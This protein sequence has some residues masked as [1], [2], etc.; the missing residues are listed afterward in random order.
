MIDNPW[1]AYVPRYLARQ[2]LD[3]PDQN[4]IGR[5]NRL[6]VVAMFSDISGF[7]PISEA[8]AA[9]GTSGAEELTEALNYY[10][11][12]MID[13]VHSYGGDVA[14]FAGDAM[15]VIFPCKSASRAAVARRAIQCALDMQ[16]G[17]A[18]YAAIRTTAGTFSLTMSAGLAIGPAISTTVGDPAL[19][20][21]HV[22]AGQVIDLCAEAE[23]RAERGEVVVHD[24]L[25]RIV[26]GIA[27]ADRRGEFS[28]VSAMAGRGTHRPPRPVAGPLSD[29]ARARLAS[30]LPTSIARRLEADQVGFVD[31]HRKVTALFVG[32]SGIDY[33]GDP[34]ACEKLQHYVLAALQITRRYDGFFS[35][36]DMGDKGSKCIVLFGTPI[37][38]EDDE[39]RALRCALELSALPHCATHIGINTGFVFCGTVGSAQ[40][41]EYT[42]I[43][44]AVN[45][46]ARLMQAAAPGQILVSGITQRYASD[47]FIWQT[48]APIRVKGKAEPV[49]IVELLA[50]RE[51]SSVN[52]LEP[53]YSLPMVGRAAALRIAAAE[54]A[55]ARRGQ[56]RIVGITAEAG[57]GKSRLCAEIVKL[58]V[59]EGLRAFGGACQ[60][61]GAAVSYL[62]WRDLWHGLLGIESTAPDTQFAGLEAQLTAID[63]ALARRM[64][65]LDVVLHIG[66]PENEM[67]STLDGK[68][69]K[70]S[71][72]DL[73]LAILVHRARQ[74][75]L[76]LVLEDCHW[77]DPLSEDLLEYLGRNLATLPV[78]LVLLYRPPAADSGRATPVARLPHF[79]EITLDDLTHGEAEQ[80]IALKLAQ[81]LGTQGDVPALLSRRIQERAQG[82]PFY[83][84]EIINFIHDRHIDPRDQQ[85]LERLEL[86]ESLYS[87][88]ISRIDQLAEDQKSTLK[89]ASA[90]GRLF[91]AY[92][93]W[94]AYPQL[95]S[96][97]RVRANLNALS[98]RGLTP[99][100]KTE[101]ELEYLFKHVVTQEVAY[102]SMAVATRASLHE[103]IGA[104]VEN[105]YAD[106]LDAYVDVLAFHYGRGHNIEKQRL[107]FRRAG[108]A[109]RA[110]YANQVA[111][112][113]Y[114]RLLPL[115]PTV[116]QV[117]VLCDL[118]QVHQLIGDLDEAESLYRQ[119]L[120]LAES[121]HQ[122]YPARGRLLLGHLLWYKAAYPDALTW[123]EAACSAFE[124]LG[125]RSGVGQAIGRM[126]L[127]YRLQAD[128]DRAMDHFEQWAAIASELGDKDGLIE[129]IGHIGN[130]NTDRR[131]F[132][133]ALACYERQLKLAVEADNRREGLN[134]QGNMGTVYMLTGHY[135]R[136]LEQLNSTLISAAEIGDR[137]AVMIGV[138]NVA[139]LYRLQGEYV[140]A[141]TGLHYALDTAVQLSELAMAAMIEGNI[142]WT[143]SDQCLYE[144]ADYVFASAIALARKL[145]IPYYLVDAVYGMAELR[146]RQGDYSAAQTHA[147]EAL[148]IASETESDDIHLKAQILA[149]DLR[150]K[151]GQTE[152][153]SAA[154]EYE[155]LLAEHSD[156]SERAAILFALWRL[157]DHANARRQAAELYRQLYSRTPNVEYRDRLAELTGEPPPALPSLP[158]LP[159][160]M[161][162]PLTPLDTLL[163]QVDAYIASS[164]TGDSPVVVG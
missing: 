2:I 19:I 108:D 131:E 9:V 141:L 33:D 61:F 117:E 76:L 58:A 151:L 86:P 87:L 98:D 75:P 118:G 134:A 154:A 85:A 156:E 158:P 49:A 153:D 164:T 20:Q 62:P 88:I 127:V 55:L 46:A 81:R 53:G 67:T 1:L 91:R 21:E 128:Y 22:I 4:L 114:Q 25:L 79:A 116:E 35:R 96:P 92:W 24:D 73:L 39:A 14:R 3:R 155:T 60:S 5:R 119:A 102:G 104:F 77:I 15:T 43:G 146:A 18:R 66:I 122:Y 56:G 38:H 147:H 136:A 78:V 59:A 29:L 51:R 124:Q 103:R 112:A 44:D 30:F 36:V 6:H 45:L 142:G 72:Q 163:E 126:G 121:G 145:D 97:D 31:E 138:I 54:I 12:P 16:A 74:V 70:E 11:E 130:V 113:Y 27:V 115:A 162:Q 82:N 17:M 125:D 83:I 8:L 68:L 143:L 120:E 23:H 37:A 135:I 80:L 129:A 10:F 94:T 7:T 47:S 13:L 84:E 95:G 144:K 69:R 160:I 105:A 137:H 140:R 109:A 123:L 41:R 107:Y 26:D 90:V 89:V 100:D 159:S 63:P 65:L 50:I 152:A 161:T 32:F 28:T 139:E 52:A 34:L 157:T 99:L 106:N 71:L 110:T 101:P 64:P 132:E 93:V 148:R 40:R 57:M 133:Q 42:V 48:F 150:V 111:I 149:I